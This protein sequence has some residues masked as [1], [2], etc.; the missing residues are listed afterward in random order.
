MY[1]D[2]NGLTPE[3]E[4]RFFREQC[5]KKMTLNEAI[6]WLE[7]F[8]IPS[9]KDGDCIREE[10]ACRLI[11]KAV[12]PLRIKVFKNRKADNENTQGN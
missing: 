7:C 3:D 9:L 6:D 11:L 10:V 4:E 12:K 2:E 1:P 8:H 5:S